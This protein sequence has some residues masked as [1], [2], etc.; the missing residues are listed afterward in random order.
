[1]KIGLS[2]MTQ[3][4]GGEDTG[5]LAADSADDPL[6]SKRAL[7]GWIAL[8]FNQLVATLTA[9]YH[10]E[11]ND[12][13]T[14]GDIHCDTISE[15]A[16]TTPMG[17]WIKIP[18][19]PGDFNTISAATWT[20]GTANVVRLAYTMVGK[21]M[22]IALYISNSSVSAA[23]AQFLTFKLPGGYKSAAETYNPC[24]IK[25]NGVRGT[26]YFGVIQTSPGGEALLYI[27]CGGAATWAVSASNTSVFGQL[28][29]EVQ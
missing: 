12:N 11:H 28:S 1:M 8:T 26:G 23:T 29:F 5:Q 15:R 10:T 17:E 21:T 22:T 19:V 2:Y 6:G 13:D 4:R 7:G 25:D 16:R 24:I 9:G 3:I 18:V 20:V 14:H 27:E